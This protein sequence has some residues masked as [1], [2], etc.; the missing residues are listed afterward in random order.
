MTVMHFSFLS[1]N[2]I[3]VKKW[4][5]YHD[6]NEKYI[7]FSGT[8]PKRV[9]PKENP[10]HKRRWVFRFYCKIVCV[11]NNALEYLSG[12]LMRFSKCIEFDDKNDKCIT[13]NGGSKGARV[14]GM[15]RRYEIEVSIGF[16]IATRPDPNPNP[17]KPEPEVTRPENPKKPEKT[18]NDKTWFLR[19]E[20]L[21]YMLLTRKTNWSSIKIDHIR[22]IKIEDP[23]SMP[24]IC[25]L[26]AFCS[27][28]LGLVS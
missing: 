14:E 13:F 7:T 23:Q 8:K 22:S 1:W 18:R 19:L 17:K 28:F 4:I 9:S 10:G 5:G 6:K 27:F 16:E 25:P 11:F 15:K 24:S 26:S 21:L 2:P 12:K 20:R 3:S